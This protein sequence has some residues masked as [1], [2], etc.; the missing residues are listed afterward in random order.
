MLSH[1]TCRREIESLHEFFVEWY[2]GAVKKDTYERVKRA[3]ASDFEMVTPEGSRRGSDDVIDGIRAQ[4]D[5]HD[6][7]TFEIDIRDVE[8]R[9]VFEEHRLMRYEEWQTT[10]DGTTGRLSTV[11][12]KTDSAAP[13]DVLWCDLHETWL[14]RPASGDS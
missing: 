4:Y 8:T 2:T 1:A 3:L 12:F 14:D 13:G 7:G 11:L 9:H 6:P 5:S 10:P